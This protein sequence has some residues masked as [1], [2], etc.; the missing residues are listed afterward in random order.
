MFGRR[1]RQDGFE[2]HKYIRTTI[3]LKREQRRER[4]LQARRAAAQQ[5]GAAGV[6]LAAGSRAV[7][8]AAR[9]GAWAGLGAAGLLAQAAWNVLVTAAVLAGRRLAMLARPGV[10]VL[11][12]PN[13]GGPVAFAG[14]IA[15]GSGIGR[16]RGAGLD[17]EALLTLGIGALLLIASL[18]LASSLTGIRMPSLAGLGITP[19][20]G[21]IGLAIAASVAG[22]AWFANGGKSGLASATSHLP[23]VG[24]TKPLQGRAEAL[25][26]D[27]VRIAG[28]TVR[29]AGIE[30][31]E[32]QQTCGVGTRRTRCGAAAKAA[33]GRLVNGRS[34]S[35][36]LSGTDS[37][38]RVLA[39]CTRG[40]TD[41][42]AELVRHGHVFAASGLF[43]SYSSQEREAR[44]AK[45]G[46]WAGGEAERP[47]EF[48]A[49]VW[50]EAKRRA[51]EGCPIKGLVTG[52]ERVYVL[53]WAPDYERGR[54]QKA[55]G[56]RW[57]C[58]EQEA[59]A[60]G[61]KPAARG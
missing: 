6:A 5:A 32:R 28:T 25:G 38:G 40:S 23:L 46:I 18:P 1:K 2:W 36:T 22:V 19:R 52:R 54:I 60:A 9:E 45:A 43:A 16:Y 20:M 11:A 48:R 4:I 7:G 34:V 30:A 33:L 56:E 14:A 55:R 8:A 10:D 29:L 49:K 26:G 3:K 17:G 12:R 31:P 15:L 13:I 42:N 44:A 59:V 27:L 58:S 37:G 21:L 53:P 39:T 41:I 47:S 57:F 35:C 50:E 24:G 51:P 61:F